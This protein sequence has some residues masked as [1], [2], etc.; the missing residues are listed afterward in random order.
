MPIRLSYINARG[1]EAILDD[2]ENSFAHELAGRDGFEFPSLKLSEHDYTDGSTDIVAVTLKNREVTCYFWADVMDIPHWEEKFDEVKSILLQT[3][4]KDK[5]WGKL[6]IRLDD[7]HYVYLNCVYEKGLDDLVRDNNT[8]VK[9]SL[10]FKATDPYFYNGFDYSYTIKDKDGYLYFNDA[11]IVNTLD[12]AKS[13]SGNNKNLYWRITRN[14]QT[15]YYVIKPSS[16]LYMNDAKLYTT[17]RDASKAANGD[18]RLWYETRVDGISKFYAILPSTTVF[19][20]TA[21]SNLKEDLYIQCEKVYPDIIINGPAVNIKLVNNSTGKK[22]ELS[23]TI[24]LGYNEQ[25]KICTTPRK[26]SIKKNGV[27][28]IPYLTADSTL[29]WWLI[30]GTNALEF[31]NTSFTPESYLKFVYTERRIS[32]R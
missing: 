6:K 3:G 27:N 10:T 24:E 30:H 19:M 21:A 25:I 11:V 23:E 7:G 31:N 13:I 18:S 20:R 5:E 8:R 22:I 2:D 12:E 16:S 26:R 15:M 28:M 17:Q 9:F 14:N 1:E 4:Q 32:V 29:D